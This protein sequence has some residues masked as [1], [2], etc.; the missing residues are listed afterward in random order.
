MFFFGSIVLRLRRPARFA[1]LLLLLAVGKASL[2]QTITTAN[3]GANQVTLQLTASGSGTGYFTLLPGAT[4][5]CGT[6]TQTASG[7]NNAGAAAIHGSLM[8]E[9]GTAKEYTVRNLLGSTEYTVCVTPDG[10]TAPVSSSFATTAAASLSPASWS[11]V[12][13]AGFSAGSA[14]YTSLAFSPDGTPYLAFRDT[15]NSNKATVVKFDG[16]QWATVGNADFSAGNATYIS[17]AFAPDGTPYVAYSDGGNSSKASVM[18]L[19]GTQ[20]TAVGGVS[21]SAAGGLYT[22]L[23]FAPDGVPYVA[24][25]DGANNY[26]A[27]VVK[28]DGTTWTNVG[29]AGFSSA[30]AD[31]V[32]LAFS[33]D[34]TPYVAYADE[35]NDNKA[36]VT[37]FDGTQWAVVGSAG[38]S[39]STALYT[40]MRFASDGKPYVT[41]ED[42]GNGYRASV[43]TFDG[44]AWTAVGSLGFTTGRADYLTMTVAPDGTPSIAYED[45]GNNYKATVMKYNGSA[46]AAVG[47]PGF[48]AGTVYYLSLAFSPSGTPYVSY[49]DSG[50][51]GKATVMSLQ[52]AVTPSAVTE[53]AS[54]ITSSSAT[55]NGTIS[56]NGLA[57]T[58]TFDYGAT[59]SYGSTLTAT[60]GGTISAGAG[61]TAASV[62]LTGL[63]SNTIYHF[64]VNATANGTMVN[65]SDASFTTDKLTPS[66]TTWPTA[67]TITYGQTL[68]NAALTGGVAALPGTFTWTVGATVPPA[69][70]AGYSVTFTPTDGTT[71]DTVSNT[72][73]LTVN[74]ATPTVNAW[75]KASSITAGQTLASS[76]LAGGAASVAGTFA[77]TTPSTAVTNSGSFA[78]IFTPTDSVDYESVSGSVSVTAPQ[79]TPAITLASSAGSLFSQNPIVLA[80][81]VS[82]PGLT[83]TGTVTFLDG[84]TALGTAPLS[85]G[86]AT[87][88][89]SSLTAGTHSITAVYSGDI[90]FASATSS[91]ISQVVADFTFAL[92]SSTSS[93][94]TIA[95]GGTAKYD[96]SISP[97][98]ASILPG[99][100]QLGVTGVPSGASYTLTPTT[101]AAGAA[102]TAVS[103]SITIPNKT[104]MSSSEKLAPIAMGVLLLPLSGL[105]RRKGRKLSQLLALLLVIGGISGLTGCGG[106]SSNSS[107]GTAS[108]NYTIMIT[109]ASG[110]LQ[111]STTVTLTVQ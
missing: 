98:S 79:I 111:H 67:S 82:A 87:Y 42:G 54:A 29:A 52:P 53:S 69:G 94:Q 100:I 104:A 57:T 72:V 60:T 49:Y 41:F 84:I 101:I 92:S 18:K 78:V 31:Y 71:Y 2:S 51:S 6:A 38:L 65:G 13:S 61:N 103:L 70:T 106:S 58:V 96:F 97:S 23:Q 99:A 24:Y 93:S 105:V 43:L 19:S 35:G 16:I 90:T 15:A 40:T 46:W 59:A 85:Y 30:R 88:R 1:F 27:T 74:K 37:K 55:L 109:G 107:P 63:S 22:S 26:N 108:Q 56:D 11:V 76:T 25:S 5:A 44:G 32:T 8:L 45:G 81:T 34:G 66:L 12:G 73:S 3:L 77:W 47:S 91:A 7:K 33:P 75:P 86:K 9:A 110:T 83:P 80:A 28:F 10:T 17:L 89:M 20:W 68:A 50:N 48:S 39:T 102:A 21:V 4:A 64:R 36:T 14:G 95:D 62:G